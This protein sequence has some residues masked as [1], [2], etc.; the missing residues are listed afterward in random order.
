MRATAQTAPL[1]SVSADAPARPPWGPREQTRFA[2]R[3]ALFMRRG[4]P[5]PEAETWADRLFE[6]DYELDGRRLCHECAHL[7]SGW[8]CKKREAV[9]PFTL[10]RCP[11]FTFQMPT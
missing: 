3:V 6:R 11:A 10:Q 1:P 9:V 4:M 7:M 5:Q 2:F 8:R